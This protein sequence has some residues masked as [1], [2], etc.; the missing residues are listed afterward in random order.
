MKKAKSLKH[1]P[2]SIVEEPSMDK[3]E[4][5]N[6]ARTLKDAEKL[7]SNKKL[8]AKALEELK[9]EMK[10]LN[11]I[12]ALREKAMEMGHEG[13]E[14]MDEVEEDEEDS[15]EEKPSKKA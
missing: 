4:I 9:K 6:A 15:S 2:V 5:E 11:S 12:Q 14:E 3:Y 13:E 1:G 7:K 8:Y 10:T